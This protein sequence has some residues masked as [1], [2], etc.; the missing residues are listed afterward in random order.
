MSE[1]AALGGCR[2]EMMSVVTTPRDLPVC[3]MVDIR[4]HSAAS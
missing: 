3:V 2:E 4:Q 1:T